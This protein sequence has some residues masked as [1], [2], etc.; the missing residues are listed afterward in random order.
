MA[1]PLVPVV[2]ASVVAWLPLTNA[3]HDE[4][5]VPTSARPENVWVM[6]A[7][8]YGGPLYVEERQNGE[9]PETPGPAGEPRGY[10]VP[11]PTTP[12][13]PFW[14]FFFGGGTWIYEEWNDVPGLQRGGSGSP[15]IPPPPLFCLSG[16]DPILDE[17]CGH[18]MDHQWF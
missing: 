13:P 5:C 12:A 3:D 1:R 9:N 7:G 2:V 8:Y 14:G 15:C 18:G 4:G 16:A 10:D 17:N 6:P 11:S